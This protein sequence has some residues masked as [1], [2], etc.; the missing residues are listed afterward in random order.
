DPAQLYRQTGG[1]PFFVTEVLAAGGRGIPPTVRDAVLARAARL[2]PPARALL[3]AV[4]VI[5]P[6]AEADLLRR[7]MGSD[8]GAGDGF[9]TG[10]IL[11]P[12]RHGY[13][14]RHEL[15]RQTILEALSPTCRVELN[16][17]ALD[18]LR[19]ASP[20]PDELARLAHH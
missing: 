14:F 1:N 9:H 20:G 7:V 12:H 17:A 19:A 10:G 13:V 16:R 6:Y 18:A 3:D 11:R 8:V 2:S 15:A 4:A 5:G